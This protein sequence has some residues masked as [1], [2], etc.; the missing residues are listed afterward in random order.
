MP[1]ARRSPSA[2]SHRHRPSPRCSGA[3]STCARC[4]SGRGSR[5]SMDATSPAALERREWGGSPPA[6]ARRR[7]HQSTCLLYA[8]GRSA[9]CRSSSPISGSS[10]SPSPAAP[11]PALSSSGAR[12]AIVLPALF[13]WSLLR[14]SFARAAGGAGSRSAARGDPVV[15]V[16]IVDRAL[17]PSRQ[18]ALPLEP[19]YRRRAQGRAGVATMYRASG[20][21]SAT[22]SSSPLTQMVLVVG[23]TTLAGYYLSRFDFRGRAGYLKGLWSC[24]PFRR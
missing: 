21:R 5:S 15:L 20:P 24:T 23:V 19:G 14:L 12:S 17:S 4:C 22:R 7:A 16:A 1:T 10:R 13:L 8:S 6:R 11:A 18:L 3:S 2:W 9:R